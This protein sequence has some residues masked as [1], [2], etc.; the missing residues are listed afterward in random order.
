MKKVYAA[1]DLKS[2]YASVECYERGLDPLTT[3]LVVAD[4]SRTDKT[5]CL[6][7]SPSLKSYGLPGRARLFEVKSKVHDINTER[8]AKTPL[9]LFLGKSSDNTKLQKNPNLALDFI[10]ATPRMQ[11]YLDYS[12]KIYNIYLRHFAPEDIFA[13]SIDEVFCDLTSYLKMSNLSPT[14][15]ITK[16]ITEV[17]QETGITATAGIGTN[18]FLA[19]VAMDIL[20]KHAEPNSAGVRIAALDEISFRKKLWHHTPITDFW[21][22]GRGYRKRLAAHGLYTMGDVARC[23]IENEDLLYGLFGINAELLID[24]SWGWE[25]VDIQDVKQHQPEHQSL[26]SGQ[27]LSI[28]YTFA[29][30]EIVLKEMSESLSL[31]L[32]QK[33]LITNNISLFIEYD[34]TNHSTNSIVDH[35]GRRA[36]KPAQGTLRLSYHTSSTKLLIKS[37]LKLYHTKVNPNFTVHKITLAVNNL[38]PEFVSNNSE[39]GFTQTDLFNEYCKIEQAKISEQQNLAKERKIQTAILK[40]RK[41]YGKN[42]I[43]R[44]TNFED[45]ATTINRH[46][47]IGGHRA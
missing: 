37:F 7:V 12:S 2:F 45:G 41:R 15:F 27:V 33:G 24:H 5:I 11:Y 35:Y 6:A 14:D 36:P 18:M 44:G 39:F 32:V 21:R 28:P 34:H 1:I 43:L 29:K 47:Q 22:V 23:S 42:A 17:Q 20:A 10:V 30:A 3:N 8:K 19:K 13:Y 31:E 9:G 38:I 25:C 4:E 16:I 46:Q 26:S 40:I